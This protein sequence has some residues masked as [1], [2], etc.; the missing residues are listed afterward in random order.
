MTCYHPLAGYQANEAG[1][2]GVKAIRFSFKRGYSPLDLPCGQCVGCRLDRSRYWATR[3]SHHSSLYE[4]NC[5]VTLTYDEAHLPKG[6]TLFR[7]HL[8]QFI[9]RLRRHVKRELGR[10]HLIEYFGCGEYGDETGR[11][12]YHALIFNYDFPYEEIWKKSDAGFP[13]YLSSALTKLWPYGRATVGALTWESAAYCARYALKKINGKAAEKH[14]TLIDPDTGEITRR[15]PEFLLMSLKRPIGKEWLRRFKSDVYP[16]D[17]VVVRGKKQKPPRYYDKQLL[18][19]E[20]AAIKEIRRAKASASPD[21]TP[22]RLK[23]REF[24]K[25]DK[26]KQL[27]RGLQ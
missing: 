17:F 16:E 15:T 26:I 14:Y 3:C 4:R 9:R 12:H 11:A 23:V 24:I 18:E 2:N 7:F 19:T 21:N 22:E 10:E 8:Q 5:F 13:A 6:N 27:K 25:L 1:P 20:A